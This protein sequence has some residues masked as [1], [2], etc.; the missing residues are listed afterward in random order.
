MQNNNEKKKR[1]ECEYINEVIRATR[2][3][4]YDG[5]TAQNTPYHPRALYFSN[6][7]YRHV[8]WLRWTALSFL[9]WP[10]IIRTVEGRTCESVRQ[11]TSNDATITPPLVETYDVSVKKRK[12]K[13]DERRSQITRS[14]V[15]P[16]FVIHHLLPLPSVY[17]LPCFLSRCAMTP[18]YDEENIRTVRVFYYF[19]HY[20]FKNNFLLITNIYL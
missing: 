5:Y 11:M 9:I 15:A 14:L 16:I 10:S 3:G 19:S 8:D 2:R 17:L 12:V 20:I 4:P 1:L 18:M 7:F 6:F 13:N